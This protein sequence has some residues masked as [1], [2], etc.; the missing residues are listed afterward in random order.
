[1]GK[2]LTKRSI[3]NPGKETNPFLKYDTMEFPLWFSENKSD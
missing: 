3:E 1:M 2:K